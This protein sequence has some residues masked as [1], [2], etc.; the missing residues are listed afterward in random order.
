RLRAFA[1]ENTWDARAAELERWITSLYPLVTVVVVS[2]NGLEWNRACLEALDRRTDWPNLEI[3][4]VDNGST[5]GTAEWLAAR[6]KHPDP[7]PLVLLPLPRNRGFAPAVHARVAPAG[8][9][10][11]RNAYKH[12][13]LD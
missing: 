3:V 7:A 5:D 1:R 12:P 2:W 10:F 9:R 6:A 4:W 13:V 8:R 11:P